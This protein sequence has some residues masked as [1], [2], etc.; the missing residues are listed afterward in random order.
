MNVSFM[1]FPVTVTISEVR[2][3]VSVSVRV[4]VRNIGCPNWKTDTGMSVATRRGK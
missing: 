4:E 1:R 2:I 3:R